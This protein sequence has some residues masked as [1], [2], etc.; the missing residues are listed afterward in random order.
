MQK[1]GLF[2]LKVEEAQ[3]LKQA[4]PYVLRVKA[5]DEKLEA[6]KLGRALFHLGVRC[7]FKSNRKDAPDERLDEDA[8]TSFG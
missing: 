7:G 1:E 4:D 6:Q 3:A 8:E 2:P 5:L